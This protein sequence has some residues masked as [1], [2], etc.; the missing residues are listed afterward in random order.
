M[1][2]VINK[3]TPMSLIELLPVL[4]KLAPYD[5]LKAI[6]FLTTEL[7]KIESFSTNDVESQSWLE[8]NFVDDLPDYDWGEE[9]V[10]I[11]KSVEYLS[12]VGLVVK[13]G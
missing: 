3:F 9:G 2:K 4:Q 13:E 11:V 6:Q 10:P 7:S 5:K 8:A 1:K 12:G